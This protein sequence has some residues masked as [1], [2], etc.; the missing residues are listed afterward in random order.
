VADKYGIPAG[1]DP[2]PGKVKYLGGNTRML[3]T[4]ELLRVMSEAGWSKKERSIAVMVA[5]AESGGSP[6][7]YN[8]YKQGHFGLFQISRSAWPEFFAGG[9]DQWADPVANARQALAIK[10]KQGWKAWEGYTND[11]YKKFANN[12]A[13]GELDELRGRPLGPGLLG[14]IKEKGLSA[15]V[16]GAV[17]AVADTAAGV[18]DSA[19]SAVDV[20]GDAWE[21]L[22]TPA[23]WMRVAYGAAGVVLLAGGLFLVVRNTGAGRAVTSAVPVGRVAK[24]VKGS[25]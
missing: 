5:L 21:A 24:A 9:S 18:V 1:G 7:I 20:L 13:S 11:R 19:A 17:D 8:T 3:G 15:V 2:Y 22:T 23:F 4:R 6:F 12:V 10:N 16:G 25:A 14:D